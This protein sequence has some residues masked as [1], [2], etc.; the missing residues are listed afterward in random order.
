MA[1][2]KAAA[3]GVTLG[4]AFGL[5]AGEASAMKIWVY[6]DST[7]PEGT[8]PSIQLDPSSTPQQTIL[9]ITIHGFW[10]ED[11][12]VEEVSLNFQKITFDGWS[13]SSAY[14][15]V[16]QPDLP[17][18]NLP[19]ANLSEAEEG[20]AVILDV[21]MVMMD[22]TVGVPLYPVQPQALDNG[23]PPPPFQWDQDF[24]TRTTGFYPVE[25]AGPF[26]PG[27][28]FAGLQMAEIGF[29]P[30][31]YNPAINQ[32]QIMQQVRV[33]IDHA[34]S[35]SPQARSASRRQ[36]RQ[37]ETLLVNYPVVEL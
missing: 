28:I 27:G 33:Q 18:I 3:L 37:Y 1:A 23:D 29:Y 20:S 4:L 11:V 12:L 24:Y 14:E 30:I 31:K 36:V 9:D 19:L 15:I 5:F 6:L 22:L 35:V 34:G 10:M 32:L 17:A 26:T 7:A 16:G 25:D 21:E 2:K 13:E 8:P